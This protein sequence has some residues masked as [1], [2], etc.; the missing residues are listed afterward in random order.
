MLRIARKAIAGIMLTLTLNTPIAP[1]AASAAPAPANGCMNQWLFNGLWRVKVTD[2]EPSMNGGAQAGWQVTETWRNG[3]AGELHPADSV[4]SDETLNLQTGSISA[5]STTGGNLSLQ[6]V[7]NNGLPPAGQEIYKQ[8]F[9]ASSVDPNDKPKS[10]DILFDN[11]QLSQQTSK[12]QFTTSHYDFHYDLTCTASGAAA[13]A[14]GGAEEMA[15]FHGCLNEW[16]NDGIW[17]MRVT[18]VKPRYVN[19]SDPTSGVMGWL[20][21][22]DWVNLTSRTVMPGAF[23]NGPIVQTSVANEYIVTKSGEN[24]S[25]SNTVGN[26]GPFPNTVVKPGGTLHQEQAFFWSPFDP[27]DTPVRYLVAVDAKTQNANPN[28][29]HYKM[30]ANFR[31]DLTCT[32]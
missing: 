13:Q 1:T 32:R 19:P 10:L 8:Q 23:D 30:P 26:E 17:K 9:L 28:W 27:T 11:R 20:V 14:K 18:A 22:Q 3:T 21:D 31:I 24:A 5:M 7:Q 6:S 29:P 2:V 16:L 15:A 25:S 4:L 12:P